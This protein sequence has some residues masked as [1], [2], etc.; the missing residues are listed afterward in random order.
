MSQLHHDRHIRTKGTGLLFLKIVHEHT[1]KTFNT[2]FTFVIPK[3]KNICKAFN[4][5]KKKKNDLPA[6]F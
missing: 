1:K 6:E 5:L 3:E 2:S 4:A